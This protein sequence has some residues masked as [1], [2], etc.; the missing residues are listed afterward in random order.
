MVVESR[1]E[2]DWAVRKG[3]MTVWAPSKLVLDA[4]EPAD[5]VA[6]AAW[7]AGQIRASRLVV[8]GAAA[9]VT[10]VPVEVWTP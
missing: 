8:V 9:P 4:V 3:R 5:A 10:T 7:F 2:L 1:T 6:L